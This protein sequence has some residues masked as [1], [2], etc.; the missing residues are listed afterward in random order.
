MSTDQVIGIR[1]R[2]DGRATFRALEVATPDQLL[3]RWDGRLLGGPALRGVARTVAVITPFRAW[4]G[5][6]FRV[7]GRM[8]NLAMRHGRAMPVQEGITSAGPSRLDG[9]PAA[10]VEYGETAAVP[11]RWMRGEVRWVEPGAVALGMLFL[12]VGSHVALGPFP[13]LLTRHREA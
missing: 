2:R 8:T 9:R 13:Y 6:E 5:K 11:T 12:P 3:G 4:C 7:G 10:I 1:S